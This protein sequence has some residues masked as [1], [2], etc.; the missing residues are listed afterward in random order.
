MSAKD[1]AEACDD[2]AHLIDG[3]EPDADYDEEAA[4]EC[5]FEQADN[6][7]ASEEYMQSIEEA[8]YGRRSPREPAAPVI[9]DCLRPHLFEVFE[10]LAKESRGCEPMAEPAAAAEQYGPV[11]LRVC[12]L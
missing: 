12:D 2:M 7:P 1:Y 6:E 10:R 9:A 3:Y 11:E 8:L 5:S 4:W